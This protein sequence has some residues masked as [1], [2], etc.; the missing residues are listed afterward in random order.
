[1]EK[2]FHITS[3][4]FILILVSCSHKLLNPLDGS[5]QY[6]P[7]PNRYENISGR[8]IE[9]KPTRNLEVHAIEKCKI[10]FVLSSQ[11]SSKIILAKGRFYTGYAYL[12]SCYVVKGDIIKRGGIIGEL[13]PYDSIFDNS[14][15]LSIRKIEKDTSIVELKTQFK[16]K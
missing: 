9:F 15:A 8:K 14:L 11:D 10:I 4:I 12:K 5:S 2:I 3:S 6:I 7:Q 13:Y 16:N 1:M